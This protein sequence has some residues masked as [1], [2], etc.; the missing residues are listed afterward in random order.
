MRV[1]RGSEMISVTQEGENRYY[2]FV[3]FGDMNDQREALIHM[4]GFLGLGD[5]PIKVPRL[6][7]CQF[8]GLLEHIFFAQV[9]I[10]IPKPGVSDAK[11]SGQDPFSNPSYSNYYEQYWSDKSAWSNYGTYQVRP[12]T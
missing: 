4:N 1:Y 11:T 2:G 3:R 6:E 7:H 5:K 12:N 10:A 9:S 8:R